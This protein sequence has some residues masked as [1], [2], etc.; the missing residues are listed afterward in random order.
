MPS[1]CCYD[2]SEVEHVSGWWRIAQP[3][4]E[5]TSWMHYDN[6]DRLS[7]KLDNLNQPCY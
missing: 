1:F 3:V 7:A 2:R 5:A 4:K 6:F